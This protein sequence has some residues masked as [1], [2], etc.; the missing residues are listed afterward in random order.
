MKRGLVLI[1]ILSTLFVIGIG[2][3]KEQP[4]LSKQDKVMLD[5]VHSKYL[6]PNT[7]ELW[8]YFESLKDDK[9]SDFYPSMLAFVCRLNMLGVSK[10][11][12]KR[13]YAFLKQLKHLWTMPELQELRKLPIKTLI[14]DKR[15]DDYFLHALAF[16][17]F[18]IETIYFAHKDDEAYHFDD[19]DHDFFRKAI[20]F[21]RQLRQM[22]A[23]KLHSIVASQDGKIQAMAL[24]PD[25]NLLATGNSKALLTLWNVTDKSKAERLFKIQNIKAA[26]TS[27]DISHD[28]KFLAVGY[29][30]GELQFWNISN[31]NE[32]EPKFSK[33]IRGN[34]LIT[35]VKFSPVGPY[36]GVGFQDGYLI[37]LKNYDNNND[38]DSTVIGRRDDGRDVWDID[39]GSNGRFFVVGGSDNTLRFIS[40]PEDLDT[41]KPYEMEF[42]HQGDANIK[43]VVFSRDNKYFASGDDKGRVYVWDTAWAASG[44]E[45]LMLS[46]WIKMSGEI[47]DLAFS[48]DGGFLAVS[49][50]KNELELWDVR[51]KSKKAAKMSSLVLKNAHITSMQYSP[52]G[53]YLYTASTDGTVKAWK[54]FGGPD[55]SL[56]YLE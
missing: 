35:S 26:F 5:K 23:M 38:M 30:G 39:V 21:R 51:D 52:D 6:G 50:K 10:A 32:P 48:P 7:A 1:V 55:L 11:H 47:S 19:S 24:S 29:G 12:L 22:F 20:K 31:P 15:E 33:N 13:Q 49:T 18:D 2:L 37:L 3:S 43:A 14:S 27:M 28:G 40:L 41:G 36:L 56:L 44:I 16:S 54:F 42:R 4:T 53:Y 46:P 9:A 17:L 34:S 45:I 8:K 25:G